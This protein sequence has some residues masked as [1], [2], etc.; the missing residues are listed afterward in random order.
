VDRYVITW[1]L[2]P[3][4]GATPDSPPLFCAFR[5][6]GLQHQE[7]PFHIKENGEEDSMVCHPTACLKELAAEKGSDGNRFQRRRAMRLFKTW[8][9]L[10]NVNAGACRTSA[11]R[12]G[13]LVSA[14]SKA[15]HLNADT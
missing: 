5:F 3:Q 11:R 4:P 6:W 7:T 2:N 15:V 9:M 8:P 13:G 14:G 12:R 10:S 1:T